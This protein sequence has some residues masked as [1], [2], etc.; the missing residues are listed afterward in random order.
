MRVTV[1][2]RIG[3]ACLGNAA[4]SGDSEIVRFGDMVQ[5]KGYNALNKIPEHIRYF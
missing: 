1:G 5:I 2:G 3:S 4:V